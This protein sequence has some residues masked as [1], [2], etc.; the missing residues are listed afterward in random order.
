MIALRLQSATGVMIM[1]TYLL[2]VNC[3]AGSVIRSVLP[4]ISVASN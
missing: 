3:T 1:P 4:W 2:H